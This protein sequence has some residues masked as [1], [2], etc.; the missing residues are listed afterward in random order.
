MKLGMRRL[1]ALAVTLAGVGA[2]SACGSPAPHAPEPAAAA[3]ARQSRVPGE[4][5]VTVAARNGVE[6]IAELYGR[7]G[8]K[9]IQDLGHNVFLVTLTEDPGPARMEQLLGGN[10]RIRAV[11][12]NFVYG[13]RGPARLPGAR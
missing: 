7:F 5:L 4:Y 6:A 11:Q 13:T 9:G 3:G 10:A 12:P 2:A 8:I 1:I